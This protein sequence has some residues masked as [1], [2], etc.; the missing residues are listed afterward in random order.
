MMPYVANTNAEPYS[1]TF[2]FQL[3]STY[4]TKLRVQQKSRRMQLSTKQQFKSKRFSIK[5]LKLMTWTIKILLG[6]STV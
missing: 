4:S 1:V 3:D 6:M 2:N 5:Y